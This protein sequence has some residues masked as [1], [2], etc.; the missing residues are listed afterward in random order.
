M[1]LEGI[2][3]APTVAKILNI[4]VTAVHRLAHRGTLPSEWVA[5]RRVWRR[6]TIERYLKDDEAQAR[7]R[8]GG[9]QGNLFLGDVAVS[10]DEVL[11]SLKAQAPAS[12]DPV[13]KRRGGA[14]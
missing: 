4:S 3:D 13:G 14:K 7:R 8:P 12:F 5:G 10:I 9:G 2:L 6:A 11:A 1:A